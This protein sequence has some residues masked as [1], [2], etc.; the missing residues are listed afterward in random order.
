VTT[1]ENKTRMDNLQNH[2]LVAMP[3]LKDGFFERSVIYLCEH[4]DKGAMGLTVNVALDLDLRT[5]LTQ[6]KLPTPAESLSGRPVLA[7]GP[8]STDRGFVLHTPMTGF[9]S[10]LRLAPE[11][12]VTTSLDILSTLGTAAAPDQYLV[13]LGYAGWEAGQLEQELL[14][15]SWLTIPADPELLFKVPLKDRWQTA[16]GRLGIDVWQLAP[17]AGHA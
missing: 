13:A 11:L 15:N 9:H 12:M 10:S 1:K 4:N 6:M 2:F 5:M 17:E 3:S 14:D 7:G 16:A 8:V